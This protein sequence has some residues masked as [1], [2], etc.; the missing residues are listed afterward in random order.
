M[1]LPL[2]GI[3]LS[4]III[5]PLIGFVYI[6]MNQSPREPIRKDALIAFVFF[7][8]FDTM[9]SPFVY[10]MKTGYLYYGAYTIGTWYLILLF[11]VP[12]A[13]REASLSEKRYYTRQISEKEPITRDNEIV[14]FSASRKS[15]F[16]GILV[17]LITFLSPVFF[18][19]YGYPADYAIIVLPLGTTNIHNFDLSYSIIMRLFTGPY[20]LSN[21]LLTWPQIILSIFYLQYRYSKTSQTKVIVSGLL[22]VFYP[23]VFMLLT[24]AS[25][26][27]NQILIP[28]P[29]LF[30]IIILLILLEEPV[31]I[32]EEIW[33]SKETSMWFHEETDEAE[34][35]EYSMIQVPWYYRIISKLL[36]KEIEQVKENE[37][38]DFWDKRRDPWKD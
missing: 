25:F 4:Y 22:S 24:G 14:L 2:P 19:S 37:E 5:S 16:L 6:I 27:P 36:G 30:I 32:T 15:I 10:Y 28:T 38:E 26:I 20:M 7:I 3:L 29:I 31:G 8:I 23:F 34:D 13:I 18:F 35:G 21:I 1:I 33:E 9:L 12:I 11:I 17:S